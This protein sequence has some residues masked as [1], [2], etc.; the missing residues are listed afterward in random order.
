MS[1]KKKYTIGELKKMVEDN[2]FKLSPLTIAAN[3]HAGDYDYE[4]DTLDVEEAVSD[5]FI[6]GAIWLLEHLK[7]QD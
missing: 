6:Y 5:A 3:E 4:S 7:A 2:P 1:K